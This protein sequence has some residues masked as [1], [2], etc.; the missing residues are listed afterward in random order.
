MQHCLR[1]ERLIH[2]YTVHFF[3]FFLARRSERAIRKGP[4]TVRCLA[5]KCTLLGTRHP[6]KEKEAALQNVTGEPACQYGKI[7][8]TTQSEMEPSIKIEEMKSVAHNRRGRQSTGPRKACCR[9][10]PPK[11]ER[12][13][14]P[15]SN[16]TYQTYLK[17]GGGTYIH[18]D[19]YIPRR[20]QQRNKLNRGVPK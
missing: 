8:M 5:V 20:Q 6:R 2:V 1:S 9:E 7:L 11:R 14:Y 10:L 13:I 12:P 19:T 3:F 16:M 15:T 4:N 18:T 17:G